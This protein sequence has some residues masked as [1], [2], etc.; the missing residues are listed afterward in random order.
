MSEVSSGM[1]ALV[2]TLFVPTLV[3]EIG[4]GAILPVIVLTAVDLGGSVGQ[5]AFMVALIGI[6]RMLGDV[7]ASALADRIG[8]RRAMLVASVLYAAALTTC[9]IA[10]SLF[11]LGIGLTLVGVST[12]TIYLARASYIIEVTPIQY[13][14]RVIS[15]AAGSQRTGGFIGP[16]VGAGAIAVA[17]GDLHG[18]Y[19]TGIAAAVAVALLILFVPDVPAEHTTKVQVRGRHSVVTV[20]RR[21]GRLYLTLG[22]AILAVGAVRAARQGVIP[23]WAAHLGVNAT[24]TSLLAGLASAFD[25]ALFYPAGK[26]M[27]LY[28]RL[29]VAVPSAVLLGGSILLMP[30]TTGAVGLAILAVTLGLGNGISSGVMMTLGAD[31][32][33]GEGRAQFLGVWR[34][35]SDIGQAA[36]P[37]ALSLLA[38]ALTLPAA[39]F[40]LGGVGFFAAAMLAVWAPKYSPYALRGARTPPRR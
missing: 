37:S 13:R 29:A 38:L 30:F 32:A 20:A 35:I 17:G 14:A 16:F 40:A 25:M 5:S 1:R 39:Y 2:P 34:L 31:A 10:Q 23:V 21:H 7:P 9:L 3:Y 8:D 28:G 36:G 33:P 15:T 22:I 19:L 6:G 12:A 26:I 18:A 11:V 4:N 24:T 27:D